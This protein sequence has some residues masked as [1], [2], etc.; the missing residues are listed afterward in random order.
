MSCWTK[1]KY[2]ARAVQPEGYGASGTIPVAQKVFNMDDI[3]TRW[4]D[5][6]A[7]ADRL[8]GELDAALLQLHESL[9]EWARSK[10]T[11]SLQTELGAATALVEFLQGELSA[12]TALVEFLQGELSAA[13][14]R[15][16]RL[17]GELVTETTRADRLQGKLEAATAKQLEQQNVQKVEINRLTV[18]RD[19]T[20]IAEYLIDTDAQ[21]TEKMNRPNGESDFRKPTE[22]W[23][24]FKSF[25][26]DIVTMLQTDY[27]IN[28]TFKESIINLIKHCKVE[29]LCLV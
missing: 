26:D 9:Q 10:Y 22:D 6:S 14:T 5:A 19:D 23:Y 7:R 29:C 4:Q 12:A 15:A 25:F 27:P 20:W 11:I 24:L 18:T 8:Q 28:S 1:H 21:V 16:D 2:Q 17:Q 3:Y 13:T